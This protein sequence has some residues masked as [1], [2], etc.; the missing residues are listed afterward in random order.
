MP[1]TRLTDAAV[2]AAKP[3]PRARKLTDGGGLYLLVQPGG[4]R[5]WRYRYKIDGV[6]NV[7]AIGEYPAMGLAEAREARARARD[8][9]KRGLH[10]AQQRRADRL[11]STEVAANTFQ[12]VAQEWMEQNSPYW[13]PYYARQVRTVLDTDVFP[14]VGALPLPEVKAAHLLAILRRVH[15]RGAESVA[16]LIRQ[17]CS[18]IFRFGVATLRTEHDPAAALRGALRRPPTRHKTALTVEGLRTLLTAVR[19][20]SA[21]EPVRIALELLALTFVRPGELRAARWEEFDLVAG[22]WRIP[23]ARMKMREEHLVPLS[24]PARA[25]L[26]QL[27]AQC[28]SDVHLFPNARD[29]QRVMTITTLN[30]CLERLGY[31]GRFSAH[32]FRATASTA[33]NELGYPGDLI[34]RQLAHRERNRVRASYNHATHL[35]ARRQMLQAWA[36]HIEGSVV[37][38][39]RGVVVDLGTALVARARRGH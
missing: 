26:L 33:L 11:L 32:A 34:E 24:T 23:A 35:P 18:A 10:P 12:A 27:R 28:S 30:R 14:H 20:S 13:T 17:W 1:A 9:V 39:A 4:A 37:E 2:R 38:P 21:T 25:L 5:L 6:E 7:F 8:L 16:V 22:L 31:G 19:A 3:Q 36:D 29:P 15:G